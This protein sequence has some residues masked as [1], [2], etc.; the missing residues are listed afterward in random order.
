[1][2]ARWSTGLGIAVAFAVCAAAQEPSGCALFDRTSE[3]ASSASCL[4]CHREHQGLGNH[5]VDVP[6]A[7]AREP[8]F[9]PAQEV[10]RRGVR[11]PGG[12]VRCTTCHDAASPWKYRVAL[13]RNARA[14]RAVNLRDRSSYEQAPSPAQPGD[15]VAAKPLCLACHALD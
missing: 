6:Y 7:A 4:S 9:R 11:I 3:S 10:L 5:S 12:E 14:V 15:E 2:G 1:V 13:P 8:D